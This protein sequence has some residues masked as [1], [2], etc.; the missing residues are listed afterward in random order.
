MDNKEVYKEFYSQII[1]KTE[2]Q[3]HA[4][5]MKEI[6][7]GQNIPP[8]SV[9]QEKILEYLEKDIFTIVYSKKPIKAK[10][11]YVH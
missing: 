8:K 10:V 9:N 1:D 11:I 2:A 7:L 5:W 6:F 4:Y 3:L